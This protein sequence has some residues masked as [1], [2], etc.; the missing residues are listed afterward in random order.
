H[1]EDR[2]L[3][4]ATAS[5]RGA[6]F[7]DIN[8]N[9]HRDSGENGIPTVT[10]YLDTN[11]NK[12]LDTA[13]KRT[14]TDPNGNFSFT[15][16]SAGSYIVRQIVPAETTATGGFELR[17]YRGSDG[18]LLWKQSTDYV[19]PPS[20]WTPEFQPAIAPSGRVY[21]AGAGGTVYWRDNIDS[22]TGNTGQ[23][24]FYGL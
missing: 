24:A 15:K 9:M 17:A 2:E 4:A 5:I 23:I 16:L 13:E 10:V 1:L 11:N 14:L 8:V 3:F 6:V 7:N 12:K 18:T 20:G 22:P 21:F 19:L